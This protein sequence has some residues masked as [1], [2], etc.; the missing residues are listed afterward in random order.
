[1]MTKQNIKNI[2]NEVNK[3]NRHKRYR[4]ISLP[5][6]DVDKYLHRPFAGEFANGNFRNDMYFSMQPAFIAWVYIKHILLYCMPAFLLHGVMF[7]IHRISIAVMGD[8]YSAPAAAF[9][10]LFIA[11][12]I[13]LFFAL[14]KVSDHM[15]YYNITM[16]ISKYKINQSFLTLMYRGQTAETNKEMA[17]MDHYRQRFNKY[18]LFPTRKELALEEQLYQ[19]QSE[20]KK[21]SVRQFAQMRRHRLSIIS[22]RDEHIAA[23]DIADQKQRLFGGAN[24]YDEMVAKYKNRTVP[25][26]RDIIADVQDEPEYSM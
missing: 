4:K 26:I 7:T 21:D 10:L 14:R 24:E 5:K 15:A 12:A 1:M 16:L 17:V 20:S 2:K 18:N 25:E 22:K 3:N 19:I 23:K 6:M 13:C 11:Y 9:Q 8:E